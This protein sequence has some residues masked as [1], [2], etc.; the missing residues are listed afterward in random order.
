MPII[1][2]HVFQVFIQFSY[3]SLELICDL[4]VT[5]FD[6]CKLVSLDF[7]GSFCLTSSVSGINELLDH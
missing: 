3:L 7:E 6:L 4:V 2:T 1:F 5:S